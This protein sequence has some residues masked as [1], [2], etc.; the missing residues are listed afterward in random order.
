MIEV[1][2]SVLILSFGVISMGGLQLASLKS[3]QIAGYTSTAATLV[4][5][6]T[7]MMRS[8]ISIS[9]I[10][11]TT[12]GVNPY[13]F[14]SSVTSTFTVSPP[15]DCRAIACTATASA[16]YHVADWVTRVK[17]QLPE[18]RVVVCRDTAPRNA[19]GSFKWSCDNLG[20]LV[21]VKIGWVD[22]RSNSERGTSTFTVSVPQMVMTAYQEILE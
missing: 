10:N 12:A 19:D 15:S 4:R 14:D 18:G 9:G 20:S 7:E 6:Y 13:L 17:A 1:L 2:I 22:K 11:T 5:D 3:N 21:T 16:Q 8:N